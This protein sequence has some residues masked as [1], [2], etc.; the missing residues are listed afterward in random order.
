VLHRDA[1]TISVEDVFQMFVFRGDAHLPGREADAEL[2]ALVH[3]IGARISESM[4]ISLAGLFLAAENSGDLP[5]PPET[6]IN[7]AAR[8]VRAGPH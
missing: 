1:A 3:E 5:R 6:A 2:E 4:R 7:L 8:S